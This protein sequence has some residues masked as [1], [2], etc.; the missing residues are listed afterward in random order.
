M[1]VVCRLMC[2]DELETFMRGEKVV[3]GDKG[4]DIYKDLVGSDL[5]FTPIKFCDMISLGDLSAIFANMKAFMISHSAPEARKRDSKVY[6][7]VFEEIEG[8]NFSPHMGTL[9]ITKYSE[10]SREL[11]TYEYSMQDLKPLRLYE[12]DIP[13]ELDGDTIEKISFVTDRAPVEGYTVKM[14]FPVMVDSY[15]EAVNDMLHVFFTEEQIKQIYAGFDTLHRLDWLNEE[16]SEDYEGKSG[17]HEAYCEYYKELY[18]REYGVTV[19]DDI[20]RFEDAEYDYHQALKQEAE[21]LMKA[22]VNREE[23]LSGEIKD[24]RQE[25]SSLGKQAQVGKDALTKSDDNKIK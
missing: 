1:N 6:M 20:D 10:P 8:Y 18:G 14:G 25:L 15:E 13:P 5:S 3:K 21:Q 9:Y 24:V 12:I 23:V 7:A 17:A 11:L 22:T 16:R 19:W 2:K 4:E